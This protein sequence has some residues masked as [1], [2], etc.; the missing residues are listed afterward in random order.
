MIDK[1]AITGAAPALSVNGVG[2]VFET[3]KSA[4]RVLSGISFDAA[5]G[6]FVCILGPSGCGK[7]TLLNLVAGFE[8][9]TTGTVSVQG[10]RVSGPGQDRCVVFQEDALFPWLT[11]RDNVAFG[12]RARGVPNKEA[13]ATTDKFL[14]LM[15]LSEYGGHLP[16]EISGG[17]KQRVALA[18]VLI[19]EPQVLLMDEPFAA[20]D[21]QTRRR[22][23]D[24][25]LRLWQKFSH[26]ILFVTHDVEEAVL[27]ADRVLLFSKNPGRILREVPVPMARPRQR[28][29][30]EC[31]GLVKELH[32]LL[33][34]D[35]PA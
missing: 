23:Q 34:E 10:R 25:L 30:V 14:R 22:M 4:E 32:A 21:A 35:S 31:A 18:R 20:L 11:V 12:L 3:G 15:E 33:R 17:M 29:S 8:F 24:L 2:K 27:L 16:R 26:T 6:E 5:A 19:L 13:Y 1:A 7:S 28:D 9:P